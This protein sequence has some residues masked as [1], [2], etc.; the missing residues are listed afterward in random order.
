MRCYLVRHA[1][2]V[3]NSQ[4]RLQGHS[5]IPLSE[6]GQEQANRLSQFFAQ[7]KL[8]RIF[9]SVLKRSQQTAAK[10]AN[11]NGHALSPMVENDLAEI[12]LGAWEG[13]TPDEIN[14]RF[15]GAYQ[16]WREHPSVVTVQD[17]EP[18]ADFRLRVRRVFKRISVDNSEGETVVVAH[19][20]VIASVLADVLGADYDLLLRRLRL[21]NAGISAMELDNRTQQVLWINSIAHLKI[22]SP[23]PEEASWF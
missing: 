12:H 21:D 16:L 11:G 5:D 14:E 10:I 4:N 13:L 17:A 18:L 6:L 3:W 19:G 2:T 1:Q 22:P 7:F 15:G 23:L 8:G 20:G 9:T